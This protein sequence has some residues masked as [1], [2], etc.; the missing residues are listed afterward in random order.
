MRFDPYFLVTAAYVA[1]AAQRREPHRAEHLAG[2]RRLIEDGTCIVAG[3]LAD[4]SASVLVVRA[5]DAGA[6]R[7]LAER[8]PY[9]RHGVWTSI[10]VA[11]FLAATRDSIG[12][13]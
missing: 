11:P 13:Q 10:E 12:R 4:L 9:W 8:D 1:D 2:V 5:E 7:A 6:A 3:A